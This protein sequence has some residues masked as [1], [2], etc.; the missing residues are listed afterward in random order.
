MTTIALN[1][2][3]ITATLAR[4][5]TVDEHFRTQLLTEPDAE[6]GWL[7]T[8]T[9]IA[10]GA[11]HIDELLAHVA[12]HYKAESLQPAVSLWFGHHAFGVM[13][14]AIACYLVEGRVPDL[15]PE[16][17]W[18]R[19]EED[20]DLGAFAWRG[21]NFAA[22]KDDPDAG[23]PDCIVLPSRDALR[24]YL[25]ASI[26]AHF[27]PII[28]ALRTRSSFGKPGLWALASDSSASA[29]T[30]VA[31]M[32]GD[33]SLGLEEARMF[34]AAPS[35]LQRKRDFIHIEHCGLSYEMP[36]RIS[37][38]LYFKVEGGEYCSSCPHRPQE[39]QVERIKSWLEKR[40]A[41]GE[42]P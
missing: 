16:N 11:S 20:G 37:C 18:L 35:P 9:L 1:T 42:K 28:D 23:H 6:P 15:T 32:L 14:V 8:A 39:E 10:P 4:L 40:A 3:P 31:E 24:E 27:I 12:A 38:C 26:I 25:R 19:F 17:V 2:H 13:A 21:H 36:E 41:A 7:S 29:F 30:W 34:G 22:M 33:V 5:A